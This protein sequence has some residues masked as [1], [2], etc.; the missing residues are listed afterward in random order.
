MFMVQLGPN[1]II[2]G[3]LNCPAG[4]RTDLQFLIVS[5]WVDIVQVPNDGLAF[6]E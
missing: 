6:T 1:L 3:A 2:W 4:G 5:N